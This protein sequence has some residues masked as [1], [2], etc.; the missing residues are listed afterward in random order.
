MPIVVRF[1]GRLKKPRQ[2]ES[3]EDR[4]VELAI[5]VGGYGRIWRSA[6]ED[7][8]ECRKKV[9]AK[10]NLDESG[11]LRIVRGVLLDLFPGLSTIPLLVT[12]EGLLIPAGDIENAQR[13]E[14]EDRPWIEVQTHHAPPIGHVMAIELLRGLRDKYV[15]DFELVDSSGYAE[16]ENF[17]SLV[18]RHAAV[19][20]ERAPTGEAF[21]RLLRDLESTAR[22]VRAIVKRPPEHPPVRFSCEDEAVDP[23]QYGTEAE[24]DASYKELLRKQAGLTRAMEE[25]TLMGKDPGEAFQESLRAEGFDSLPGEEDSNSENEDLHEEALK[26]AEEA[27]ATS[28]RSPRKKRGK[29]NPVLQR[30]MNLSVL[31]LKLPQRNNCG[32][33]SPWSQVAHGIMEISGGLAQALGCAEDDEDEDEMA[34]GHTLVQ[35]KRALQ[36]VIFAHCGLEPAREAG[37]VGEVTGDHLSKELRE[38]DKDIRKEIELLREKMEP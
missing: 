10:D 14:V 17:E 1:R 28:K 34:Y 8:E 32:P 33:D 7:G 9:E 36:G 27:L 5:E 29:R 4:I 38:L 16:S 2:I 3:F 26:A 6:A 13:A 15:P 25:R 12:P 30:A 21:A 35:L 22:Q 24:W 19:R 23:R 18:L 37:Q 11:G 31:V 20:K